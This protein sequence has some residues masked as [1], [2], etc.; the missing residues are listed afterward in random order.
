[1]A[2]N[3]ISAEKKAEGKNGEI[4]YLTKFSMKLFLSIF[5]IVA[6]NII[7]FH[8]FIADKLLGDTRTASALLMLLGCLF[9]TGFENV[10]KSVFIGTQNVKFTAVSELSEQCIRIFAVVFLLSR[11]AGQDYGKIAFLIMLGMT[12]SEIFSVTYLSSVYRKTFLKGK[13]GDNHVLKK[14]KKLIE[15][16]VLKV[17]LPVSGAALFDNI[18]SSASSVILPKCLETSGLSSSAAIA[19]L[20][21]ISGV[22]MPIILLPIALISSVATVL[23]PSISQFMAMGSMDNV[24]LRIRKAIDATGL[25]GIPATAAIIPIAPALSRVFFAQEISMN[26]MFA[27]G[28]AGILIYYQIMTGSILNGLG[29]QKKAVFSSVFAECIQLVLTLVLASQPNFRVYGYILAMILSAMSANILN[30]SSIC[31][32]TGLKLKPGRFVFGPLFCGAAIYL[33]VRFFYYIFIGIVGAQTKA[34]LGS[35]LTAIILYFVFLNLIGIKTFDY[36]KKIQIPKDKL[37][38]FYF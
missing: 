20:G 26:Y 5:F 32:F 25:I 27:L 36:I 29:M 8:N 4:I 30:F 24:R 31:A 16:A 1:M 28:I 3:R 22:A 37:A 11:F 17:A 15:S 10:M 38:L 14:S 21:I 34:V 13:V 35:T 33:W 6:F 18:I 12:F 19:Q 2:C 7:F 23:L 9:L